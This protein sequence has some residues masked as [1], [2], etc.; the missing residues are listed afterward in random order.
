MPHYPTS[1]LF[2]SLSLYLNHLVAWGY[3]AI[4]FASPISLVIYSCPKERY[5]TLGLR[6]TFLR[7][8]KVVS[9]L[10]KMIV[11]TVQM[12]G[13]SVNFHCLLDGVFASFL[14]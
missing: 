3:Y 10:E 14:R 12:L 9:R 11:P 6:T 2:S 5:G 1:F 7:K 4:I 13:N 8:N